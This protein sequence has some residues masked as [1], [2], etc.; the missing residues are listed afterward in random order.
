VKD[1]RAEM[2]EGLRKAQA[3]RDRLAELERPAETYPEN[4]RTRLL[5]GSLGLR[6]ARSVVEG[7][8]STL[9]GSLGSGS[10]GTWG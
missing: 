3:I 6:R 2:V 5:L 7:N 9:R 10:S 1:R 8:I 4:H